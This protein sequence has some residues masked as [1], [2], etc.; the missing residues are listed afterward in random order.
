MRKLADA[1]TFF[2]VERTEDDER[3]DGMKV[4]E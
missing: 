1:P 4:T 2:Q 3:T